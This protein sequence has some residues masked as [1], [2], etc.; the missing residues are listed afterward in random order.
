LKARP[1]PQ[2]PDHTLVLN[3]EMNLM[4]R[5][6]LVAAPIA[7][8]SLRR[9]W[10][11]LAIALVTMSAG[12][13]RADNLDFA[14]LKHAPEVIDYLHK[15]HHRT[16]GVL[17]FR[18]HK[19]KQRD[20]FTVGPL[21]HNIV[22]RLE[23]ALIAKNDVDPAN[24]IGIIHDANQVAAAKRMG[25]YSNPAAQRALFQQSYPL[26]WGNTTVKPDYLLTGLVTVQPDLKSATVKIEGFGPA[27]PK[28]DTV[29]SFEVQTDRSLLSDLNESFHVKSRHLTKRNIDLDEEAVSDAAEDNSKPQNQGATDTAS[30]GT[31]PGSSSP[32]AQSGTDLSYEIRFD[33]QPQPVRPDP[34]SPGEFLVAEPR[35]NQVISFYL[36]SLATERIGV[37]LTVNGKSTLYEQEE[38]PNHL[39]AWVLEPGREYGIYGFQ[40]ANNQRKPFRVLSDTESAA[41][42]YSPNLGLIHFHIYHSGSSSGTKAIAGGD[43][44]KKDDPSSQAM[45]ISL[46][47]L[48]RSAVVKAGKTRSL[49]DLKKTIQQHAGVS[50]RKRGLVGAA[51]NQVD[52]AIQND[53]IQNPVLV[54]TIVV[55]YYKPKGQ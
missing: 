41:V 36:K 34:N 40:L 25:R 16:V 23:N 4:I 28:Q 13:V 29:A 10:L 44:A 5:N 37:A 18:I 52:S 12:P 35:E 38:D 2:I 43:T 47:G 48:N 14:L 17:K 42:S 55:R 49:A 21:N 11:A 26:A 15:H 39:L 31:A 19:G 53:A 9:A 7:R 51:D 46:R 27:S 45:N 6:S 20:S 30:T 32:A 33:G 8:W 1:A 3:P 50:P 54:Q 24:T 22:E